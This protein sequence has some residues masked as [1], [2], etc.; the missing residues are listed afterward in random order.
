MALQL[1]P[2]IWA[3]ISVNEWTPLLAVF[4][5]EANYYEKETLLLLLR[6]LRHGFLSLAAKRKIKLTKFCFFLLKS[7]DDLN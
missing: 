2:V 3:R 7:F 5:F 1:F 6:L 4:K